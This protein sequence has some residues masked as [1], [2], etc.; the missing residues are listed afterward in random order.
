MKSK[1]CSSICSC[2]FLMT[3]GQCQKVEVIKMTDS[4][5]FSNAEDGKTHKKPSC[6]NNTKN[7]S[8]L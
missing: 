2:P 7:E 6:E 8:L 3:E 5:M 1:L 4:E